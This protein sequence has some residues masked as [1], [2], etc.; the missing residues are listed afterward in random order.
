MSSQNFIASSAVRLG[1]LCLCVAFV[2]APALGRR[3]DVVV[4]R[5][6]DHFTGD[7]KRLENGILYVET[8]NASGQ[9]E[10]D[11]KQVLN[12]RSSATYQIVLN[13]GQRLIGTIEKLAREQEN[14]KDFTVREP[15]REIAVPS[16]D[17]VTVETQKARFWR[18]LRGSLDFGYSFT[19]GNNQSQA[20]VDT[21]ASYST[22]KWLVSA[23]GDSS[24][25][26]QSGAE[27]TNRQDYQLE[28]SRYLSRN[29][30]LVG[31]GQFLHSSQQDLDLR[32]T[33]GGGYGRYLIRTTDTSFRWIAGAAYTHESFTTK[34][35]QPTNE[36]IE[37]LLGLQYELYRFNFGDLQS[38]LFVFPGFSDVG[39]V[40]TTTNNSLTIK[41]TNNFHFTFSF[42]DN[43]DSKPP[44]TAK[45]NELGL[46]SSIGWS[47]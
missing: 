6:G 13:D 15:N 3:K 47:F 11:W 1:W 18:Q 19:S 41:L 34:V 21:N 23:S 4:M 40:R 37:G 28:A 2:C 30:F 12:V 32:A 24:F 17:V 9:I 36:N 8:D 14:E 7:V 44:L 20:T 10:L 42:W 45:R 38:Q 31:L 5:N 39:R 29:S 27:K 16:A 33:A 26:G 43:F 22:T 46:S 25:S 35:A